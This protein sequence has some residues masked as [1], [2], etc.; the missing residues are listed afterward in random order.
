MSGQRLGKETEKYCLRCLC[1]LAKNYQRASNFFPQQEAP[2]NVKPISG[3]CQFDES[4]QLER[5]IK[6]WKDPRSGKEFEISETTRAGLM[7]IVSET[8]KAVEVS[9]GRK[10]T[11]REFYNNEAKFDGEKK[12]K[13]KKQGHSPKL[14]VST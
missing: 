12:Q 13:R 5:H 2:P 9:E 10:R 6:Y 3:A 4:S 7:K 1:K 8:H 14:K 11:K